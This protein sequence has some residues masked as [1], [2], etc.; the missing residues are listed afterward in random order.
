MQ[1]QPTGLSSLRIHHVAKAGAPTDGGQQVPSRRG[2]PK[3][4]NGEEVPP[5]TQAP[6]PDLELKLTLLRALA[7]LTPKQR[8]VLVLRFYEDLTEQ[9][10]AAAMGVAAGTIKSQTRR[11]LLRLRQLRL[12]LRSC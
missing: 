6:G 12:T 2:R 1:R 8:T 9:Q 11:A 10:A 3:R 5:E 4:T 7:R